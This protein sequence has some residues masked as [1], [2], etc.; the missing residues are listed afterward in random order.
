MEL[1]HSTTYS[2][3]HTQ[4]RRT[5]RRLGLLYDA[6]VIIAVFL[7]ASSVAW[8]D[9]RIWTRP[10]IFFQVAVFAAILCVGKWLLL[11]RPHRS[12]TNRMAVAIVWIVAVYAGLAIWL[13]FTRSYYSRS[14]LFVSFALL[15]AWQVVDAFLV[16]TVRQPLRLAAVPSELVNQLIGTPGLELRVLV[17]PDVNAAVDGIVVD[18]HE[19][20]PAEWT[21]FLAESSA[22]GIPVYHAA[23]IY[24]AATTRVSLEHA[25]AEW[26]RELFIGSA[27]Y[28]PLKRAMDLILVVVSLPVTV[29][30]CL[31]AALLVRIGSPGPVLFWQDRVGQRGRPFRIVKFRSMRVDAEA[32][33]AQFAGN[34]DD[35]VTP[36]GRILRRFRLDEL[37]Q[38]WNVLKGDM[39]IIGPRPEQ[40]QFVK[41]FE[42]EIPFYQW[43][44]R[45][46]PGI[47][48]WAQVQ[49]GYAAGVEDTMEKLEYDLYYVKHLS[50]WLDLSIMFRTVRIILT[51]FGAR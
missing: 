45:V 27:S 40:V 14:F 16:R 28:L 6:S 33:G 3:I 4:T 26:L 48:G 37:P 38:L 44:H 25:H 13:L 51:G 7:F 46:K 20:L 50:V 5:G 49:Q 19:G 17:E 29:P 42:R 24:E 22:N 30:L 23:S 36:M 1:T 10:S 8:D 9:W 21:R 15:I 39:S 31:M 2:S 32:N 35:R 12:A 34:D 43:R 18:M 11:R 47:T 41:Q